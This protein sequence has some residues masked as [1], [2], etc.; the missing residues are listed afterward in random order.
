[1]ANIQPTRTQPPPLATTGEGSEIRQL[2]E[3]IDKAKQAIR[4]LSQALRGSTSAFARTTKMSLGKARETDRSALNEE[5]RN[6]RTELERRLSFLEGQRG[7]VQEAAQNRV[8]ARAEALVGKLPELD[9][10]EIKAVR[11]NPVDAKTALEEALGQVIQASS[12]GDYAA[13]ITASASARHFAQLLDVALD[14]RALSP[15]AMLAASNPNVAPFLQ[16]QGEPFRE[17]TKRAVDIINLA[18][19]TAM[20]RSALAAQT[21]TGP[22]S[23][24]TAGQIAPP[25]SQ[26]L[27][28][29]PAP[30]GMTR[31]S[32]ETQFGPSE[33]LVPGQGRQLAFTG[34]GDQIVAG[35][36]PQGLAQPG[37]AGAGFQGFQPNQELT[38]RMNI[39]PLGMAPPG[40]PP[41]VPPP[42]APITTAPLSASFQRMQRTGDP[43]T[44]P[45]PPPPP[46]SSGATPA[47]PFRLGFGGPEANLPIPPDQVV[48]QQQQRMQ[49]AQARATELGAL[50]QQQNPTALPEQVADSVVR[51]LL[52]EFPDLANR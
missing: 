18:V 5:L 26:F 20:Q 3:E 13:T 8:M 25:G 36:V 52:Q 28:P 9:Q 44:I 38:G 11:A 19:P 2:D 42:S 15:T 22:S 6:Q 30:A 17:N 47:N 31:E 51:I 50:L 7:N 21:Q 49:Q 46:P 14:P 33:Q 41:P 27:M 16:Q 29:G 43:R 32:V 35:T 37:V 12:F 48:V 23:A 34:Q 45:P 1:M 39:A 24:E 10:A 4:D 40:A